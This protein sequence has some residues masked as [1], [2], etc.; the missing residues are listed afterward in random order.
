[1]TAEAPPTLI[2]TPRGMFGATADSSPLELALCVI[3]VGFG[4][5][6][7]WNAK[8]GASFENDTFLMKPFC[9]CESSNCPWCA[10]CGAFEAG[11]VACR[12]HPE[13]QRAINAAERAARGLPNEPYQ[14]LCDCGAEEA[15]EADRDMRGCDYHRGAGIFARFAPWTVDPGRRYYD[16]PNFWFKP[17]DFRVTWYKYIG[18]D[19]QANKDALS[20]DFLERV[21]A[22][23]PRGMTVAEAIAEM[24]RQEEATA[25][26]FAKMFAELGVQTSP[27]PL[28]EG[29]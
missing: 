28:G 27:P 15:L 23:H 5:Q 29:R 17:D 24:E 22:T 12:S 19:M 25:N 26:S 8:Y 7:E 21:F 9:W 6:G 4:E 11:C 2:I 20:G 14:W 10:G 3:G 1:M 13:A 16:P 18:R